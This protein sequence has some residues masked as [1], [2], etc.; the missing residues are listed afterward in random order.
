LIEIYEAE[1]EV[2]NMDRRSSI[3]LDIRSML[4]DE[5]EGSPD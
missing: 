3:L 5:I 4:E 1:R 2:V